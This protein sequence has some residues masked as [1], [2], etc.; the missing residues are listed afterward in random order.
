MRSK[1]VQNSVV[2]LRTGI[3]GVVGLNPGGQKE[4]IETSFSILGILTATK[5]PLKGA[6]PYVRSS[7]WQH[8][9]Y[10]SQRNWLKAFVR[11]LDRR[12]WDARWGRNQCKIRNTFFIQL[13]MLFTQTFSFF[14]LEE[15]SQNPRNRL[16]GYKSWRPSHGSI[17]FKFETTWIMENLKEMYRSRIS[18]Q[19][20]KTPAT[21]WSKVL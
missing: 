4:V 19:K 2:H 11:H 20:L 18:Y 3:W 17:Q 7:L 16:K 9:R 8:C 5:D 15:Y 13:R 6:A 12:C 10:W 21:M 1:D 14:R